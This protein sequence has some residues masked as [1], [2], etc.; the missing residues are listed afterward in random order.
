LVLDKGKK[1]PMAA[2]WTTPRTWELNELVTEAHLNAQ[3]RDNLDWMHSAI[4]DFVHVRDERTNGTNGGT[5][6]SG[7]WRQRVL[8]TT[9][10]NAN[11]VAT[12]SSNT[13]TLPAGVWRCWINAPAYLVSGHQARLYKTS[14]SEVILLGTS[15]DNTTA[16]GISTRSFVQGQ[17]VLSEASILVV[18]HRCITSR[19]N[20]GFGRPSYLGTEIYTDAMFWR[21]GV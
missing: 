17:F 8:N 15:E 14:T 18:E 9:V 21:V 7:A 3:I 19:S 13:L 20:D 10:T 11:N 16:T 5:F 12:L 4:T 1:G 6:S 2:I